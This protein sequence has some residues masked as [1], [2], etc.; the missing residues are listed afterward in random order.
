[1]FTL[2]PSSSRFLQLFGQPT[3]TVFGFIP[4]RPVVW[5]CSI[6]D[7]DHDWWCFSCWSCP[8]YWHI[9]SGRECLREGWDEYLKVAGH[10][11]CATQKISRE[12]KQTSWEQDN[13][14]W[15]NLCPEYT[16]KNWILWPNILKSSPYS[17]ISLG[18]DVTSTWMTWLMQSLTLVPT[19]TSGNPLTDSCSITCTLN[20]RLDRIKFFFDLLESQLGC[21]GLAV[22]VSKHSLEGEVM[23]KGSTSSSHHCWLH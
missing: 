9:W 13:L 15:I 22:H 19:T 16:S 20:V 10:K 11:I 23:S 7:D 8:L 21:L 4:P 1:M 3:T 14:V 18:R 2:V 17:N 6:D 12:D 5:Q